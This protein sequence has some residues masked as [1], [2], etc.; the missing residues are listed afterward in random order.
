MLGPNVENEMNLNEQQ[1]QADKAHHEGRIAWLTADAP[2]WACGTPVAKH[3]AAEMLLK[4]REALRYVSEHGMS[5]NSADVRCARVLADGE[6]CGLVAPCPDCGRA[7][8]D[9][10]PG[11]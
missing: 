8:H 4:S 10:G 6:P 3:M 5:T 1:R 2:R 11:A 9:V 7:C